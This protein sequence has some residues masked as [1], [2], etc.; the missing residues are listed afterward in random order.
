M[1]KEASKIFVDSFLKLN[2]SFK[3]RMSMESCISN[4][5]AD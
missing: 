2:F 3:N 1:S 5:S 4:E